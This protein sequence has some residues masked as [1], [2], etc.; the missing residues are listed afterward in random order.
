MA[1]PEHLKIL[2]LNSFSNSSSASGIGATTRESR[3]AGRKSLAQP[4]KAGKAA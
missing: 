2:K 1:N 4:F 3:T